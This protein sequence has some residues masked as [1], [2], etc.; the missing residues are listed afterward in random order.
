MGE[1]VVVMT[2]LEYFGTW[3][4]VAVPVFTVLYFV[5]KRAVIA[6]IMAARKTG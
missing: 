2:K 6:A 3:A 1:P 4:L 5:V